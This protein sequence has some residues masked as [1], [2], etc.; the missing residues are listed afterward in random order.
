MS[1]EP[2]V[3]P[4]VQGLAGRVIEWLDVRTGVRA[5]LRKALDEPIPGGAR[6]A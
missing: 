4:Q 6:F 2:R 1:S 3:V 5:I